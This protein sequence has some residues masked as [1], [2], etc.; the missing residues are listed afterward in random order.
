[1]K[2]IRIIVLFLFFCLFASC[3]TNPKQ[4]IPEI[5]SMTEFYFYI[6]SHRN[7]VRSIEITKCENK[8]T[9]MFYPLRNMREYYEK[10]EMSDVVFNNFLYDLSLI[11]I[12]K[13]KNIYVNHSVMDG[14]GWSLNIKFDDE[15]KSI[16]KSGYS[17]YPDGWHDFFSTIIKYFPRMNYGIYK[18]RPGR[19]ENTGDDIIIESWFQENPNSQYR[20]TFSRTFGR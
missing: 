19:D 12:G 6:G 16:E 11:G 7:G 15:Q 4:G 3:K 2:H 13:W 20:D 10:T 17:K 1:M 9:A 5:Y 14:E 8:I 18:Y